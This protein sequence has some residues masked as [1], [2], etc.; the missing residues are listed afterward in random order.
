M[1]ELLARLTE[2]SL[3]N[4]LV[5]SLGISIVRSSIGWLENVAKEWKNDKRITGFHFKELIETWLRVTPQSIGL[6][7]M[8]PGASIGA[9]LTDTI[10]TSYKK[11]K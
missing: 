10:F 11:G 9:L 1:Y 8:V 7:A 3:S 2:F 5:V 4:P 6:D